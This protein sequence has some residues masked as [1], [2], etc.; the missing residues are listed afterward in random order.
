MKHYHISEK[1]KSA[2]Q[3]NI[4]DWY[5]VNCRKLPWREPRNQKFYNIWISEIMLQQT[6]VKTVI[7][8]YN[9]FIKK[10]P[11]IEDLY[12]ATLD[13]IL[14]LWQGLG[15]YQRAK[16]IFL[17]KEFMKKQKIALNLIELK[18][19]PGIGDYVSS[20]IWRYTK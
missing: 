20:A 8:Y 7:P 17:A 6:K 10:W 11:N 12:D 3:K 1:F 14:T 4:L 18:K 15:Y 16:N 9:N 19:L 5:R 13:E 2:W